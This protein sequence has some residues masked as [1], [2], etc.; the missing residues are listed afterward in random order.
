[1]LPDTR[2][3]MPMTRTPSSGHA[4]GGSKDLAAML[5]GTTRLRL[6]GGRWGSGAPRGDGCRTDAGQVD[7]RHRQV[8]LA[9]HRIGQLVVVLEVAAQPA[10]PVGHAAARVCLKR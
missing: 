9:E 8:E 1:M 2:R 7:F 3:D 6:P 4:A 5:I 10:A